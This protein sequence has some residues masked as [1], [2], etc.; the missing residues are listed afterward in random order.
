[1]ESI[2]SGLGKLFHPTPTS[3]T[4]HIA[5]GQR[6]LES[7]TEEAHTSDLLYPELDSL[8]KSQHHAFPLKH[9]D[10]SSIVAAANSSDD[11]GGLSIH[12]PR[13]IRF[14]VG[15]YIGGQSRVLFD[16]QPP[17]PSFANRKSLDFDRSSQRDHGSK[18]ANAHCSRTAPHT[19]QSSLSQGIS[20]ASCSL[21]LPLSPVDEAHGL[22]ERESR[23]ANTSDGGTLHSQLVRE[24]RRET[25]AMLSSIFGATGHRIAAGMKVHIKPY[26]PAQSDAVRLMGTSNSRLGSQRRRTPLTRS[27][28]AEDLHSFASIQD[29]NSTMQ[30]VSRR[31]RSSILITK[32]FY[33]DPSDGDLRSVIEDNSGKS[34]HNNSQ[35]SKKFRT[36]AFAI[37]MIIYVPLQLPTNKLSSSARISPAIG[38]HSLMMPPDA[39]NQLSMEAFDKS[40]DYIMSHWDT[41]MR[42]LSSL[43]IVVRC[44][45]SDALSQLE[46]HGLTQSPLPSPIASTTRPHRLRAPPLPVLQLP[47]D[48]LQQSSVVN[49]ALELASQRIVSA[50]QIRGVAV[51]QGRWGVWR[52]EARGVGHWAGGRE[53]NFFF[54]NLLTAFLGNHTEWLDAMNS[55]VSRG[56]RSRIRDH[57]YLPQH[58]II[59]HRTVVV[60]RD[61]MAARR[62]I[63]LL[64]AFLPPSQ[65]TPKRQVEL[66]S[67]VSLSIPTPAGSP[68][69]RSLL[70][71]DLSIIDSENTGHLDVGWKGCRNNDIKSLDLDAATEVSDDRTITESPMIR[72]RSSI[73]RHAYDFPD[74]GFTGIVA[75]PSTAVGPRFKRAGATTTASI[76]PEHAIPVAHFSSIT[77]EPRLT[78][79][80][81]QRPGSSSSAASFALHRTLSRSDSMDYSGTSAESQSTGRWFWNSRRGSSTE[82]SETPISSAEGLGIFVPKD[83]RESRTKDKIPFPLDDASVIAAGQTAA[84]THTC[85]SQDD[86]DTLSQLSQPKDIP[87]C[88]DRIEPSP[89]DLS[90]NE[91]DGV[92][93]VQLPSLGSQPSSFGSPTNSP[94]ALRMNSGRFKDSL[95]TVSPSLLTSSVVPS[96]RNFT[97]VSG[98][99][100][101]LRKFH[102]DLLLQAV[103]PHDTLKED[104]KLAMRTEATPLPA[105]ALNHDTHEG[106][107]DWTDI[108]VTLV[109]DIST[110]TLTRIT[111]RRKNASH[112][113]HQADA[114]LGLDSDENPQEEFLEESLIE[115][116][117]TLTEA[118]EKILSQSGQ[119]SHVASE[120]TSQA[121]Q[122]AS[123]V[124]SRPSSPS[125]RTA[126][127]GERRLPLEIHKSECRR[128]VL[129]ALEQVASSVRNEM[130]ETTQVKSQAEDEMKDP[131]R[132]GIRRWFEETGLMTR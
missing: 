79:A 123:R 99:A 115:H 42:A 41:I 67:D 74:A 80:V 88:R 52:D 68:L 75:L 108:C 50:F 102:Q 26:A 65:P 118:V 56:K 43:E 59:R 35:T 28:T 126:H 49:K 124:S 51:G 44:K 10:P 100:G 101:W 6:Q 117:A 113:R 78:A 95:R 5:R 72:Q 104:I 86:A 47:E 14:I 23:R 93:D 17:L 2:A 62:V 11:R 22:F 32:I 39:P 70:S 128:M 18:Q 53:Q 98:V 84:R 37:A 9:G 20:S 45:I 116:D 8:Q 92:I 55:K 30:Q 4:P 119:A 48:G 132:A 109:A 130:A 61:K 60:S 38:Q 3:K 13:D 81:D 131:L 1:M 63:F 34:T 85:A 76:L 7:V 24:E 40:V 89:L 25:D 46:V 15:Q 112:S 94:Q 12:H 57:P 27:T 19:R 111:L 29:H 122:S 21:G 103:Q 96:H 31:Q 114:L 97:S 87:R 33:L 16:T 64:S 73:L 71:N 66:K 36:P 120:G 69:T 82:T 105:T 121:S 83:L 91:I 129:G 125:Q 58:D 107:Q 77:P 127:S 90:V 106:V 54:F 110:F